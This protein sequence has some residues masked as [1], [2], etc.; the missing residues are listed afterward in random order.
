[1]PSV[2]KLKEVIDGII[3]AESDEYTN[4]PN[5]RGGPTK[6]GITLATLRSLPSYGDATAADVQ[7]LTREKAEQIYSDIY[8]YPF[9]CIED[10]T[11]FNFVVNAAVQH[12]VTG[13]AR[14]LQRALGLKDD[15][16]IGP[17]TKAALSQALTI[18]IL[19]RDGAQRLLAKLTAERCKYYANILQKDHSQRE[20]AAGWLN[21]IAKDLG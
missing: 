18:S 12:G 13:A 20:F 19:S 15:G 10:D 5:D 11:I 16:I 21:R 17:M 1:M 6:Y 2:T 9:L 4:N 7:K 8:C 14:Q 3:R